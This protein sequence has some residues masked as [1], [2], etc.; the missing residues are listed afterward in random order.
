MSEIR[1]THLANSVEVAEAKSQLDENAKHVLGN[2]QVLAW[3]VKYTVEEFQDYELE[4]IEN[5][6]E[7]EP[8]IGT[9]NIY[10]GKGKTE[11]IIGMNSESVI[12]NEGR[13][14]FDIRFHIL[15]KGEERVKLI[16]NVE[17]QNSYYV[18]Y[19]HVFRGLFYCS[20]MISEQKNTE[21]AHDNYQDLKKVY[22]IWLY[23]DSPDYA[24]HTIT[25][26]TISQHNLYGEYEEKE[27]YDLM[28]VIAVRL[29][30]NKDKEGGNPLHNMLETLFSSRLRIQ[31][32]EKKLEQEFGM[33]MTEE[34]KKG[35]SSMCNYS[36]W[37]E[38]QGKKSLLEEQIKKKLDKNMSVK[39]IA[40]A[41]E[42]EEGTI[43]KIIKEMMVESV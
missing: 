16:I 41:L 3:I 4:E 24:A 22:S 40:E 30:V 7:G 28:S 34:V 11:A 21:F 12:P 13:A 31:E 42:Q 2:K 43:E 1:K 14:A 5:C 36:D 25:A 27:R 8:E 17:A 26:Y 6:I 20:R 35:A 15:T 32:K 19:P 39:E 18:S 29:A 38:E 33:R 23:M 10:P 9:H 37:V